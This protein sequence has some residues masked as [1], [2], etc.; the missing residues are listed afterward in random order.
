M[1]K[2]VTQQATGLWVVT[3]LLTVLAPSVQAE[4][5]RTVYTGLSCQPHYPQNPEDHAYEY[6]GSEI[7]NVAEDIDFVHDLGMNCAIN[8]GLFGRGSRLQFVEVLLTDNSTDPDPYA[9]SN[10]H[11]HIEYDTGGTLNVIYGPDVYVLDF[12]A[13]GEYQTITLPP[14][15]AAPTNDASYNI[16]CHIYGT[17]SVVN[18]YT[19]VERD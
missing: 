19:V 8:R 5:Q 17:Y 18:R 16:H 4:Q 3:L 12:D 7:I 13:V 9:H 2:R 6:Y 14:T 1:H 15:V 11:T 10:C